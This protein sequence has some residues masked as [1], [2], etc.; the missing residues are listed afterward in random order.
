MLKV[1][2]IDRVINGLENA[3]KQ[4][5]AVGD[6]FY[7]GWRP[8][9]PYCISPEHGRVIKQYIKAEAD[10]GNTKDLKG[11]NRFGT[12]YKGRKIKVMHRRKQK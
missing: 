3:K 12:R 8:H 7:L 2:T 10:K 9:N 4:R 1:L 5:Q 6:N 11:L